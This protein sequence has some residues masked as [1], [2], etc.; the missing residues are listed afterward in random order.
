MTTTTE[1]GLLVRVRVYDHHGAEVYTTFD[2][3]ADAPLCP[4]LP[5]GPTWSNGGPEYLLSEFAAGGGAAQLLRAT[6]GRVLREC[7]I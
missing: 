7:V 1:T 6:D 2:Y 4:K 5:D 3:P